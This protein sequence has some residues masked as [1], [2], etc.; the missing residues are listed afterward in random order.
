MRRL[1]LLLIAAVTPV[2][3][4]AQ[5]QPAPTAGAPTTD[6]RPYSFALTGDS[7]ITRRL[8]VYQEPEFLNLI[9]LIRRADA[10]FTNLEMLFHDYEMYPMNQ[11]G[12]TYMRGDPA[13][14]RDLTWAGFDLVA[15]ANNHT[16][17]YGVEGMRMT[18]RHV[19]EAG[20][21]QAGV[22]ESLE[23]ARE[24]RFLET[25]HGRV[26]LI[27]VASTFPDHARASSS[28]G[29]MP[30]RPGLNPLR[31]STTYA[32]PAGQVEALK[33]IGRDLKLNPREE[34]DE[35]RIFGSRFKTGERAAVTT[36]PA[37]EDI[38]AI[39][40]SVRGASRLSDYTIVSLHAHERGETNFVPAEF[41]VTFAHAMIDAGATMIVGHGP[42]VLRG[43][44]IYK[45]RPI[46]Y[47]LG[48][49]MFQNET[50]L[51]LPAENYGE[52][53]LGRDAQVAD[54]NDARY[55]FDRRG[56]PAQ[57]EI[58][59]SVVAV[60]EFRGGAMVGLTLHPIV[61]GFGR[62]PIER[63]RPLLASGDAARKIIDDV[64]RHSKSFGT[65]VVF[66]HGVGRVLV[67]SGKVS[68]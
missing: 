26:A 40:A 35:L 10:S 56:F 18:T 63:G 14:V 15:R 12:G 62:P 36:A 27:S 3:L 5:S 64:A 43:I 28:R 17:D 25:A 24:A 39:A 34:G 66:E 49:F 42:H 46:F 65:T 55:D 20:L 29:D 60:P 13:L 30:A 48:D 21:V 22:G 33:A 52:Y 57:R 37:E 8:A 45:G 51:R 59:E 54:F 19:A 23:E 58:W 41:L 50:V 44:E 67:P 9:D 38:K 47:S 61:L 53:A 1:A 4:T 6:S 11:S 68:P 2:V 16:G 32:L 31:F 7:I